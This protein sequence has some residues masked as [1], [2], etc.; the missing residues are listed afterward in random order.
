MEKG[1]LRNVMLNS[2][3][4]F[5]KVLFDPSKHQLHGFGLTIRL[6]KLLS[7]TITTKEHD[8]GLPFIIKVAA[9]HSDCS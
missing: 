2:Y 5:F 3:L 1:K 4:G 6:N 9:S 7:L 8:G